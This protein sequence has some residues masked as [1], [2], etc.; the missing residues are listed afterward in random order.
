MLQG[1]SDIDSYF[2]LVIYFL[3]DCFEYVHTTYSSWIFINHIMQK[4]IHTIQW[5]CLKNI[6]YNKKNRNIPTDDHSNTRML[7]HLHN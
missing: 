7:A 1:P 5:R 3:E 4:E 2:Y 6:L